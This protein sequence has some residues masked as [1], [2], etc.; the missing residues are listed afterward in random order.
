MI[1]AVQGS[2]LAERRTR[3]AWRGR[4]DGS[5]DFILN[6]FG[7]ICGLRPLQM[8]LR[9]RQVSRSSRVTPSQGTLLEVTL[10]DITPGERVSA[11]N[12][13]VRAITGV[14]FTNANISFKNFEYW[15]SGRKAADLRRSR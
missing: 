7:G 12:T 11:E 10:Q 6:G 1:V 9:M 13:H 5:T 14:F 15:R 2:T 8:G 3:N 4:R